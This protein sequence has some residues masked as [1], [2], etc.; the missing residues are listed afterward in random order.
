MI[1]GNVSVN[2]FLAQ[3][4]TASNDGKVAVERAKVSGMA[5]FYVVPRSHTFIMNSPQVWEQVQHFL[6]Y[7]MFDRG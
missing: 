3:F 4:L 1:P 7:G 6:K 2:P 5:D